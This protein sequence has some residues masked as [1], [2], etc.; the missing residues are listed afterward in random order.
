M[1]A[2]VVASEVKKHFA[3]YTGKRGKYEQSAI[4]LSIARLESQIWEFDHHTWELPNWEFARL[5][6]ALWKSLN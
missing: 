1:I 3:I 5:G 4:A 6:I 2:S